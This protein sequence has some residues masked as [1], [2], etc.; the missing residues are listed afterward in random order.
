MRCEWRTNFTAV[1]SLPL[2]RTTAWQLP[3]KLLEIGQEFVNE[4]IY[5]ID[6]KIVPEIATKIVSEI[7]PEIVLEIFH[8]IVQ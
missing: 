8:N 7:V 1:L 3:D 6:F 4:L 5:E 2:Y